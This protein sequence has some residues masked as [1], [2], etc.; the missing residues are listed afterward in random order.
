MS[1][2]LFF[3]RLFAQELRASALINFEHTSAD[4]DI[5]LLVDRVWTEI[6]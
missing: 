3:D 4:K 6:K 1:H 5:F 2:V